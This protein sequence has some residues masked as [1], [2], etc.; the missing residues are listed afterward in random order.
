MRLA[1]VYGC[2]CESVPRIHELVGGDM[3]DE[4]HNLMQS[5]AEMVFTLPRRCYRSLA[6]NG[7]RWMSSLHAMWTCFPICALRMS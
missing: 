6:W 2:D 1:E 5:V 3:A 7:A 4:C